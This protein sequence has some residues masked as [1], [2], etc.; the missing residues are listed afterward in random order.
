MSANVVVSI[1]D[2]APCTFAASRELVNHVQ[3]H[4]IRAT[5]LVVPGPWGGESMVPGSP[6]CRWLDHCQQE[7]HEISMHG[8][9][10]TAP[11]NG[12]IGMGGIAA[13]VIARGCAEFATLDRASSRQRLVAGLGAMS[14]AGFHPVGFTPPGWLASTPARDAI[15]ALGFE[16]STSHRLIID[17]RGGERHRVPAVCQRP[18]SLLTSVGSRLVR[19]VL[20]GH[21]TSGRDVRLALHPRDLST[22][23]LA[24]ETITLIQVAGVASTVTYAEL[25]AERR[26]RRAIDA[27][28]VQH[29]AAA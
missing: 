26:R 14:D 22:A 25:I 20:I 7:G 10:H 21:V 27:V 16:Y 2:V 5:L 8:W 6:F 11:D 12:V 17:H 9:S 3:R 18:D 28:P 23:A 15:G 19:R 24:H 4:G 1:H 13:R 29:G